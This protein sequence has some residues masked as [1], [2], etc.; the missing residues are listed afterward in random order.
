MHEIE[1]GAKGSFEENGAREGGRGDGGGSVC[2]QACLE[3]VL[4]EAA[5]EQAPKWEEM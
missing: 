1:S 2:R 5:S 3:T 4:R